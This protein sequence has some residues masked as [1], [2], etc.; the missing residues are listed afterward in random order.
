MR[1]CA[2]SAVLG[3]AYE[4]AHRQPRRGD[5]AENINICRLHL[6]AGRYTTFARTPRDSSAVETVQ[7]SLAAWLGG[8]G[9]PRAK[10]R[11]P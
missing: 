8:A 11:R 7:L 1:S 4:V 6:S 2:S 3:G 10:L 5:A 9:V